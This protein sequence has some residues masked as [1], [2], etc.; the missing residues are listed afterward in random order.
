MYI[1]FT[2]KK[3]KDTYHKQTLLRESYREDGKVEVPLEGKKQELLQILPIKPK[4]K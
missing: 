1:A 2:K 3:Y 4:S